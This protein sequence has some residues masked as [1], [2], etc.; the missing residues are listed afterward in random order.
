MEDAAPFNPV[1]IAPTFNNART[2]DDILTRIR[3]TGLPLIVVNDGS[4]DETP[5]V[6]EGW[7][8]APDVIVL[9]HQRNRGKAEALRTGFTAAMKR[10]HTHA[11]TID[12]DAQHDPEQIP[13]LLAVARRSP[14]ALVVGHRSETQPGYPSKSL[15]GRRIS[16][17]LI[18]M[19]SGVRVGDSQCG[20]RIYPLEFLRAVPCRSGRFGLETEIL[21]RAGWAG[22]RIVEVGINCHYPPPGERVSHFRPWADSWRGVGMH[23]RLIL[24]ALGPWPF[25]KWPGRARRGRN[26]F[27]CRGVLSWLNPASAWRQLRSDEISRTEI[28]AGLAMGAFI[29]N[30]PAYG[31]QTLLSLY[32]ARR[33][34]L[35]PL[36]VVVGSQ[37]STP[38]IGPLLIVAAIGIGH[39]LLHGSMPA[40]HDYD[41]SRVGAVAL[42]RSVALEWSI[43]GVLMGFLSAFIVFVVANRL[44][45]VTGAQR[46]AGADAQLASR[47]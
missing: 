35:H 9:V 46:A 34:H 39:L 21:V 44:F 30:L 45:R 26:R 18:A 7:G 13:N 14:E 33:L 19:E 24:R 27:S 38:P 5:G 41:I 11:V 17:L 15:L 36:S 1:V 40:L 47:A 10:G 22:C 37:L 31:G 12:T 4:T 20:L 25:R 16:N 43:G 3:A 6:L 8:R 32:A 2:L 23:L 28:S 42:F 29:A